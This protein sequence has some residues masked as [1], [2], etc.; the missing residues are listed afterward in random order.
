MK[1]IISILVVFAICL[2]CGANIFAYEDINDSVLS[3]NPD[4]SII[5]YEDGS[6]C[7]ITITKSMTRVATSGTKTANYYSED[8]NLICTLSVTG[9]FEYDGLKSSCTS[10]SHQLTMHNSNW[11]VA[12]QGSYKTDYR[13]IANA[14]LNYRFLGVVVNTQTISV[15]LACDKYGNLS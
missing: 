2:L 10:A 12:S 9:V 8:G 14:T 7:V 1:R 3:S 4:E 15:Q 6:Y 13:A 11:S 5:Y